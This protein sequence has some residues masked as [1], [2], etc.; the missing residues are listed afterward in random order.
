MTNVAWELAIVGG[1]L[2]EKESDRFIEVERLS[3]IIK[4]LRR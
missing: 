2:S 4:G 1:R 3:Q